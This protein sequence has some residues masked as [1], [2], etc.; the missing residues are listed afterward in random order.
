MSEY[1][2]I[3]ESVKPEM[4]KAVRYLIEELKKIRADRATPSLVEDIVVDCFDQRLPLKQL[5]AISCPEQ[6]QILI[7]PWDKSY[8]KDIVLAL[9]KSEAG[10]SPTIEENSIRIVLPSLTEE[11]RKNL[12]KILSDKKEDARVSLKRARE[13]VWKKIQEKFQQGEVTEDEKYRSKDELQE[14]IDEYNKKV[15]ETV[16]KREREI[17]N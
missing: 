1:K 15:D 3:V 12:L 11:Y 17:K 13:D 10:L 14:I 9:Q 4:E 5:A 2:K 7:Q 16:E 6:R 8:M